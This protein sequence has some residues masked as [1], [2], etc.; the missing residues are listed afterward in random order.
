MSKHKWR[1]LLR[2]TISFQASPYHFTPL[3]SLRWCSRT[4]L[5]CD[6]IWSAPTEGLQEGIYSIGVDPLIPLRHFLH[7]WPCIYTL[8]F[9]QMPWQSAS[10]SPEDVSTHRVQPWWT[11]LKM[12][13]CE[14]AQML[15]S[16]WRARGWGLPAGAAQLRRV[17][18]LNASNQNNN[19]EYFWLSVL[20]ND[21]HQTF[22]QTMLQGLTGITGAV[23][24]F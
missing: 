17:L 21:A 4:Q 6:W 18:L 24:F 8:D 7:I 5:L 1:K 14:F 11:R 10:I 19:S 20:Q 15:Y 2:F 9:H 23:V 3:S 22:S 16:L 13:T 12:H